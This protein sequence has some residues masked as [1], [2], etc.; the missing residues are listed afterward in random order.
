MVTRADNSQ[1]NYLINWNSTDNSGQTNL[2]SRNTW[3]QKEVLRNFNEFLIS[4][5]SLKYNLFNNDLWIQMQINQWITFLFT[6]WQ[7]VKHDANMLVTMTTI[8]PWVVCPKLFS[9]VVYL[10]H[11]DYVNVNL[12]SCFSLR[13][14]SW[15][16]PLLIYKSAL[17]KFVVTFCVD[18]FVNLKKTRYK[19]A[20]HSCTTTGVSNS[21]C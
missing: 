14:N 8:P 2:A 15:C 21:E 4:V 20:K 13:P 18:V 11:D 9:P 10:K 19:T 7:G 3:R 1:P 12:C 6:F 5:W 17:F 16:V